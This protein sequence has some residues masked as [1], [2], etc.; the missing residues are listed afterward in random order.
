[1]RAAVRPLATALLALLPLAAPPARADAP[2]KEPGPKGTGKVH[3][4]KSKDGLLYEYFV[5]ESY[6]EKAGANLVLVFHGTGLDR[7]WTFANHPAGEFRRDDIVVSA[8]GPVQQPGARLYAYSSESLEAIRALQKELQAIFKVRK[9]FLYGHSQ[10]AFFAFLYAA[11]YPDAVHG[12][13]GHAGGVLKGIQCTKEHAHQAY[14]L[15]HGT[16]DPV[17][18]LGNSRGG[19]DWYREQGH[20]LVHFRAL[21]GWPH[22]P[23]YLQAEMQIAWMEGMTADDPSRVVA[24][25][26]RFSGW[27]E[28]AYLDLSAWWKVAKRLEGL[29]G[30]PAEARSK[31]AGEAKRIESLAARHADAIRAGA[32]KDGPS[33]VEANPWIGHAHRFLRDFEGV[34]AREALA[35]EWEKVLEQHRSRAV[36]SLRDYYRVRGKDAKKAFEEGVKAVRDGFLHWECCDPLLLD[37][38]AAWEKDAK[39]HRLDPAAVKAYQQAVVPFRESLKDGLKAFNELNKGL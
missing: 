20:A 36:E 29:E 4:W 7:R 25:I 9:V 31:A 24:A 30:A 22:A 34:P 18:P 13:L 35:R 37:S 39:K 8:D 1:M 38:L 19:A 12:A 11:N 3:T 27:E 6:D 21:E 23:E 26:D 33:K 2:Q 14:S 32:G 28:K 5:P 10:G 16:A 15:M 17:V